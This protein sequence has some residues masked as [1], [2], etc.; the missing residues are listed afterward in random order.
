MRF[1]HS[2]VWMESWD[3]DSSQQSL[4]NGNLGW[5]FGMQFPP[6]NIW[7]MGLQRK[8]PA[9]RASPGACPAQGFPGKAGAAGLLRH[10]GAASQDLG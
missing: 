5:N 6:S 8:I 10:A 4:V 2:S 9:E 7:I 1:P 3:E